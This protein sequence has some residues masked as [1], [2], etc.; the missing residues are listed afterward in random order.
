M[1]EYKVTGAETILVNERNLNIIR[2]DH[3][4][5]LENS[6]VLFSINSGATLSF[7]TENNGKIT[8]NGNDVNTTNKNFIK[9]EGKDGIFYNSGTLNLVGTE[10][11]SISIKNSKGDYAG[12]IH[13]KGTLNI[14]GATI[15]SNSSDYYAGGIYNEGIATISE[16]TT[17]SGNSGYY[18]GAICNKEKGTL[19]IEG[20]TISSNS[21]D[22]YA[23]GIYNDGSCTLKNVS[24]TNN[25]SN[26][27]GKSE[28]GGNGESENG[29]C[30]GAG[31]TNNGTLS[32]SDTI[33][34]IG[35]TNNGN[36]SNLSLS[37]EK[38]IILSGTLTG[39][40]KV[41]VKVN[42]SSFYIALGNN[43]LR[44]LTN[45]DSNT[46]NN[47]NN[48]NKTNKISELFSSDDNLHTVGFGRIFT[49]RFYYY[50]LYLT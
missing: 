13:N 38:Y 25:T 46:R 34:I 29:L 22:A 26:E 37:D 7:K 17:M 15:S 10:S 16:T 43:D 11:T 41:G 1:S 32:I 23:G 9:V 18:A 12:A 45:N 19:G 42:S 33:N 3:K 30:I 50:C 44:R 5:I 40:S 28:N 6:Y 48:T 20:A 47:A 36:Q 14:E 31:F 49:D 35:N 8:F 21:S 4:D 27:Y 39:S 24:I 2:Y